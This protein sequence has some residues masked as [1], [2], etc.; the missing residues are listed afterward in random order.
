LDVTPP[1]LVLTFSFHWLAIT[2]VN[3][4]GKFNMQNPDQIE[5][6]VVDYIMGL[7]HQRRIQQCIAT[8]P[9]TPVFVLK[10]HPD[11]GT[12]LKKKET[13]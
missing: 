7:W 5:R 3:Q 4:L 13:S 6:D 12:Y 2:R 9:A 11:G 8:K 10:K 1:R